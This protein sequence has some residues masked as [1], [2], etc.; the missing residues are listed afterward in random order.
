MS[1]SDPYREILGSMVLGVVL[2]S[3]VFQGLTLE[4][5]VKRV[6][7]DLGGLSLKGILSRYLSLNWAKFELE[8]MVKSGDVV[9]FLAEDLKNRLS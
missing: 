3:L 1:L 8:R 7:R 4:F 6:F 5:F 9:K 2:F